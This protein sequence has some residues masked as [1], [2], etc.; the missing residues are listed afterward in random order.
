MEIL[1]RNF[2]SCSISDWIESMGLKSRRN[3]KKKNVKLFF[4]FISLTLSVYLFNKQYAILITNITWK[5]GNTCILLFFF[6]PNPNEM[7][8]WPNIQNKTNLLLWFEQDQGTAGYS[9]GHDPQTSADPAHSVHLQQ[10]QRHTR[11]RGADYRLD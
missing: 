1:R 9:L 6:K 11:Q 5:L 2:K 3:I 7:F 4:L 8:W 10:Y